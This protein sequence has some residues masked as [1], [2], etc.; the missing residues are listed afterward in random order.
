MPNLAIT[1]ITI[2]EANQYV[3]TY[4]RHHGPVTGAK[5][6]LAVSD[7]SGVRG[8]ALVGRPV[9]R[10]YD[11]NWTLEVN[12]CC[13]DGVTN[14][15]SMLYAAAW[16]AARAMGYRRLITYT[17]QSESG[18]SLRG[19]GWKIIGERMQRS[20]D[21]PSRPRVESPNTGQKYLWEIAHA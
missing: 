1:P 10:H 6:A 9:A 5:F 4:H 13:T 7:E 15:C 16:R 3:R 8:V 17:L 18:A 11:D 20:W 2:R 14:G 12:R 21:M 19:A